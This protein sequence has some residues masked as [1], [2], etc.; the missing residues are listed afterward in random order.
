[1]AFIQFL[2]HTLKLPLPKLPPPTNRF[3][4]YDN[5]INKMLVV[6][7]IQYYI[8][9]HPTQHMHAIQFTHYKSTVAVVTNLLNALT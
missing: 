4:K 7:E 1:M 9:V 2:V 3:Y 6:I 5:A 8:K